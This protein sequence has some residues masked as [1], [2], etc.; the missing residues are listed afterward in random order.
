MRVHIHTTIATIRACIGCSKASKYLCT[1]Q[2]CPSDC[3]H[4]DAKMQ[5]L[6]EAQIEVYVYTINFWTDLR[7]LSR[8]RDCNAR[9]NQKVDCLGNSFTSQYL[10]GKSDISSGVAWPSSIAV[11]ANS[12]YPSAFPWLGLLGKEFIPIRL[13]AGN[14]WVRASATGRRRTTGGTRARSRWLESCFGAPDVATPPP[15]HLSLCVRGHP[16]LALLLSRVRSHTVTCTFV[17]MRPWP[18]I[19]CT[20]QACIA[21]CHLHTCNHAS[22]VNLVYPSQKLP[23]GLWSDLQQELAHSHSEHVHGFCTCARH[24]TLARRTSE[25]CWLFGRW[26]ALARPVP[27]LASLRNREQIAKRPLSSE[28]APM[29]Y[30]LNNFD[31]ACCAHTL[32]ACLENRQ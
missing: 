7:A 17:I 5:L 2:A 1:N 19:T 16:S 32:H 9:S 14:R 6:M 21:N 4:L 29:T 31:C 10:P 28:A 13:K 20:H 12:W 24:T 30:L 26:L 25:C 22:A 8:Y 18:P 3:R 11:Q 23:T 15:A 27:W